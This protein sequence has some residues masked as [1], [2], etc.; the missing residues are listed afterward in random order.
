M[1]NKTKATLTLAASAIFAAGTTP[2]LSPLINFVTTTTSE[3]IL[4]LLNHGFIAATIGGLADWFAVTALFRKP[5]GISY[6]TEILKRNRGRITDAIIDF[7]SRDLLNTQNILAAVKEENAAQMLID[8][9]KNHQGRDKVK[10]LAYEVVNELFAQTDSRYI[11]NS[12]API[13][14][15]EIKNLNAEKIAD[16]TVKV[17]TR[18]NHSRKILTVLLETGKKILHSNHMQAAISQKITDLREA[19][20][21]DSAGRA[22][23]LSS[24]NLTDEKILS[25]L[26]E[27]VD[28]KIN[29]TL[30]V[31]NIKGMVDNKSADT[32]KSLHEAFTKFVQ[33]A[34]A[35]IDNATFQSKIRELLNDKFNTA[36]YIQNWLD[37][38]VRGETDP[39]ILEKIRRQT[40][41]NPYASR[42][43]EL[44]HHEQIWHPIL[45]KLID[46]KID[47]FIKSPVIQ[48]KFDKFIKNVI[49]KILEEYHGEIPKL[50]RE[51]LDKF[52]DEELTAFVEGKVSDD[53]QMIRINGSVCGAAVGML[54]YIVAQI[55]QHFFNA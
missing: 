16:A 28:K 14:E 19:Y 35:G 23:V 8:Y 38:N 33:A 54:L 47:E 9:L 36:Q 51:R 40:A 27:N 31:L 29:D 39:V 13:I 18:D 30:K 4:G 49:E 2:G 6:R 32:A 7:V 45:D 46:E 43:I 41:N 52:S 42:I 22:L 24:M 34:A 50:I 15:D 5:L 55:I 11:A 10:D 3:F 17:V 48:Y 1:Q 12:V 37:V 26:N 53:L 44:E 21:G 20:E 25:I